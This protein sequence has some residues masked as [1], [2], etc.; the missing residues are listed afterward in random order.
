MTEMSGSSWSV[1]SAKNKL[2]TV[3]ER[4][5]WGD[6][7]VVFKD[8]K[9]AVIVLSAVEYDRLRAQSAPKGRRFV[10]SQ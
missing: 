7:Q 10:R 4:A 3:V 9:K 8:G 5:R 2:G 6:P 1:R